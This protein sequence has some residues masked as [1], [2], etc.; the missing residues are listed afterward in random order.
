MKREDIE[1]L[2]EKIVLEK[3]NDTAL[4]LVDVGYVRERDWFLRVYLDKQGGLEIED[5]QMVS[6][7]LT[8]Y[9]DEKD[10]IKEKYYLEVSSPGLDRQLKK[11]KDFIRH[12]G[13]K[14][15]VN[16]FKPVDGKKIITGELGEVS[17]DTLELTVNGKPETVQRNLIASIRLHLDF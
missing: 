13:N 4:E 11:P 3:I 2:I 14:V 6:E 8:K 1:A 10:P 15:D 17:D 7:F 9:L 16:F 12:R 5:C